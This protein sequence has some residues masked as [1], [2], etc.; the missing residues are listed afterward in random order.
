MWRRMAPESRGG[1]GRLQPDCGRSKGEESGA[2]VRAQALVWL[3]LVRFELTSEELKKT[4][5]TDKKNFGP[6]LL[7]IRKIDWFLI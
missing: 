5:C 6:F 4:N 2:V 7:K 1:G 3:F